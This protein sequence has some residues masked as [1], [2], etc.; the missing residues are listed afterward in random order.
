MGE[1]WEAERVGLRRRV[2]VK[3]LLRELAQKDD[4][5]ARFLTETR[6]SGV[7]DHDNVCEVIDHGVSEDGDLFYVMPLLKG[8][9]LSEALRREAPFGLTRAADITLQI[10]AGLSA[11]HSAGIVHRDLKPQNVFLTTLGDRVDFVK[12]FDFGIAKALD[13]TTWGEEHRSL[14]A[15]GAVLGTPYYMA[16]EQARGEKDIDGRIDL[17]A[18]GVM[19]YQMLTGVCPITG[20]TPSEVFWNIW[21][22]EIAPPRTHRPDL[23]EAIEA[24]IVKAMARDRGQR[25]AMAKDFHNA[26][27]DALRASGQELNPSWR[28]LEIDSGAPREGHVETRRL[29]GPNGD[30]VATPT[31]PLPQTRNI[32]SS[33]TP[34]AVARD[35]AATRDI[36]RKWSFFVVALAVAAV[37]VV[38][39]LTLAHVTRQEETSP[40]PTS[41]PAPEPVPAPEPAPAQP[42]ASP[43]DQPAAP[44]S[45]GSDRPELVRITLDGLPEGAAITVDGRGVEGPS[46]EV[47]RSGGEVMVS[48]HAEGHEPWEHRVSASRSAIVTVELRPLAGDGRIDRGDER[49]LREPRAREP[50]HHPQRPRVDSFGEMP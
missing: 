25:F 36:L 28:P 24:V 32:E 35:A 18:V 2:A 39:A 44:A 14:T 34:L 4:F 13:S 47:P 8:A 21:M 23:P 11:A 3:F 48:V 1:V 16:P 46:F 33:A 26:V 43:A 38:V 41:A 40:D 27:L 29:E 30:T 49:R 50:R 15:T 19:L 12:V 5:R 31:E 7:I 20:N 10:L 6:A 42:A 17:Y 9:P 45:T 22:G 37:L